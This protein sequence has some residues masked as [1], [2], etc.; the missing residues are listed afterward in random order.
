MTQKQESETIFTKV[1]KWLITHLPVIS[2]IYKHIN[3]KSK[4]KKKEKESDQEKKE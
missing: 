2:E 4:E 1:V 3:E